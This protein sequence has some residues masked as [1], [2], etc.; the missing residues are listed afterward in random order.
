VSR[1]KTRAPVKGAVRC[2]RLAPSTE[3]DAVAWVSKRLRAAGFEP[4]EEDWK[5]HEPHGLWR[6]V[7]MWAIAPTGEGE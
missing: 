1:T 3:P 7:E 4:L 6:M 5:I 2:T